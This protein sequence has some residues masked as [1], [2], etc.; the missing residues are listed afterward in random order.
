MNENM[1]A[2]LAA[3]NGDD[4]WAQKLKDAT[5]EDAVALAL[6]KAAELGIEL[7]ESDFDAPEGELSEDELVAVAGGGACYCLAG[8]G[9]TADDDRY[10]PLDGYQDQVCWCVVWGEGWE[11]A[12]RLGDDYAGETQRCECPMVGNGE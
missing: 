3:V 1:K 10:C 2:F 8:G 4:A 5:K 7:S 12:F 11:D 6:G 9:G